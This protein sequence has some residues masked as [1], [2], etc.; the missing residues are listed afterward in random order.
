MGPSNGHSVL[1]HAAERFV[2]CR[3]Q[4]IRDAVYEYSMPD[5]LMMGLDE[6]FEAEYGIR[7]KD[8][9]DAEKDSIRKSLYITVSS[10]PAGYYHMEQMKVSRTIYESWFDLDGESMFKLMSASANG[11]QEQKRK[12]I[13]H[14]ALPE[15]KIFKANCATPVRENLEIVNPAFLAHHHGSFV[16]PGMIFRNAQKKPLKKMIIYPSQHLLRLLRLKEKGKS[17]LFEGFVP[18]SSSLKHAF[19]GSWV[20]LFDDGSSP[21]RKFVLS[22]VYGAVNLAAGA[23]ETVFGLITA[24]FEWIEKSK[25]RKELKRLAGVPDS[26]AA[27]RELKAKPAKLGFDRMKMG[28][29]D[30][31]KSLSEVFTLKMRYPITTDWTA[32][33]LEFFHDLAQNSALLS[34]MKAEWESAPLVVQGDAGDAVVDPEP[35]NPPVPSSDEILAPDY[36]KFE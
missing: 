8:Y 32:E 13:A 28:L 9:S 4:Q 2:Y 20:L 29:G 10:N 18:L 24:P 31:L 27:I 25:R 6:N 26:E 19:P 17:R 7:L 3:D 35:E 34:F 21:W 1:G 12:I 33:E 14:E 11:Y 30:M 16:T 23:A 22:P 36:E 15:Y 5:P